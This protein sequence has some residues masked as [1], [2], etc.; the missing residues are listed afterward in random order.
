MLSLSACALDDE[1]GENYGKR[2]SVL[3]QANI[4]IGKKFVETWGEKSCPISLAVTIAD[5]D[6][7]R[8]AWTRAK[9]DE[10]AIDFPCVGNKKPPETLK[11]FDLI[12][13]K[14]RVLQIKRSIA[15]LPFKS[16]LGD[17]NKGEF[18]MPNGCEVI[19][20]GETS[21]SIWIEKNGKTTGFLIQNSCEAASVT[22]AQQIVDDA[23][24]AL[25]GVT[26]L[27]P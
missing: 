22:D 10:E 26:D 5:N 2:L 15:R 19:L 11:E 16:V 27:M 6:R 13:N 24:K 18:A 9:W 25:L 7:V 3:N 20:G 17:Q 1:R 21:R 4:Y 12:P 8:A 14:K 23:L